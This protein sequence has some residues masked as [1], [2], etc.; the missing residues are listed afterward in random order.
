MSL[1]LCLYFE[2]EKGIS[3]EIMGDKEH[4]KPDRWKLSAKVQKWKENMRKYYKKY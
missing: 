4:C 3:R 2:S 1:F